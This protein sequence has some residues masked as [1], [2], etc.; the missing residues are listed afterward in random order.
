MFKLKYEN[1]YQNSLI[2]EIETFIIHAIR[3]HILIHTERKILSAFLNI[4][5][6]THF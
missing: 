6:I 3:T 5:I 1:I 2:G 4:Y